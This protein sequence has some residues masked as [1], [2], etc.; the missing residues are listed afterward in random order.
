MSNKTW[1]IILVIVGVVGAL[2]S[3]LADVLRIGMLPDTFG[4]VQIVGLILGVVLAVVGLVMLFKKAAPDDLTRIEGI[5]PQIRTILHEAG[6][7]TF[8]ALAGAT[9]ERLTGIVE[10]ADFKAPFDASS[11][12]QQAELAAKGDWGALEALQARLKGG[13]QE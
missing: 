8:R 11:W 7:T 9:P 12:P 6:L 2:L 1:G 3:V 5:G 10:A 4:L 13:R